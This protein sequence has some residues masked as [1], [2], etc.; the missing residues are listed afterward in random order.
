MQ[1][2]VI[3]AVLAALGASAHADVGASMVVHASTYG[4]LDE[5]G[6]GVMLEA[7][8]RRGRL[9]Y[10]G[11]LGVSVIS[12]KRGTI[13]LGT[14]TDTSLLGG[15]RVIARSFV[16]DEVAFELAIDL[17]GGLQQLWWSDEDVTRP[18]LG[19]GLGWQV[20]LNEKTTIRVM[21]RLYAAPTVSD[22][23][24]PICRGACPEQPREAALGFMGMFGV[25]W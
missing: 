19:A 11:D 2:L 16:A 15:V 20:R 5:G 4:G 8:R 14:G 12:G 6:A 10:F 25:S 9:E 22:R 3:L 21:T 7:S 17:F 18:L 23:D 13:G 24:E 1:R